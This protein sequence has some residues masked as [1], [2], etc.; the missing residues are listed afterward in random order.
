MEREAPS[1]IEKSFEITSKVSPN[2]L[3]VDWRAEVVSNVSLDLSTKKP[4][5][6]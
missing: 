6:S 4:E 2:P 5:E 1:V 3:S